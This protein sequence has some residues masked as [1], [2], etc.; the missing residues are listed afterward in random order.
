MPSVAQTMHGPLLH[1]TGHGSYGRGSAIETPSARRCGSSREAFSL[2]P[3]RS[4]GAR[5]TLSPSRDRSDPFGPAPA[6]TVLV[7]HVRRPDAELQLYWLGCCT[8]LSSETGTRRFLLRAT[9][10]WSLTKARW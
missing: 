5:R 4:A 7:Q 6:V 3:A 1:K 8:W 10:D 9:P 2:V